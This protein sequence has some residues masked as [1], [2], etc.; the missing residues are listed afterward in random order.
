MYTGL[1]GTENEFMGG[2]LNGVN[3][4]VEDIAFLPG[5]SLFELA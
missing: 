1:A 4:V 3:D 2:M 5:A